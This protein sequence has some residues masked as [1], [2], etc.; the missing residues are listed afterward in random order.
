MLKSINRMSR[1]SLGAECAA[2]GRFHRT[3]YLSNPVIAQETSAKLSGW[4]GRVVA[5]PYYTTN[6]AVL[7]ALFLGNVVNNIEH[8]NNLCLNR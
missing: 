5:W 6:Q 2:T 3:F 1:A 4:L 7:A 8:V